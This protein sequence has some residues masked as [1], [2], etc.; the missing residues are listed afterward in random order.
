MDPDYTF[1]ESVVP[2][3]NPVLEIW[4]AIEPGQTATEVV[5]E[6]GT[7]LLH[8]PCKTGELA[9]VLNWVLE[10]GQRPRTLCA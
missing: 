6:S 8:K 10:C 4:N 5:P 9:P 1:P 7:P 2:Q 3:D